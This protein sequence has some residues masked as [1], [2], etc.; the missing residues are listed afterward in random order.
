M[1]QVHTSDRPEMFHMS[2]LIAVSVAQSIVGTVA[3]VL[4][5]LLAS[6]SH[7]NWCV[8]STEAPRPG[9]PTRG[10][11]VPCWTIGPQSM[12]LTRVVQ[13]IASSSV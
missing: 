10:R 9:L 12:L 3:L 8:S 1:L 6:P 2:K 13:L 4:L 7:I 11:S 5:L